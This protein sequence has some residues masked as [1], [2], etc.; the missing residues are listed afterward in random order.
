[1]DALN[2]ETPIGEGLWSP[3]S[4][5]PIT[6]HSTNRYAKRALADPFIME[7]PPGLFMRS[8][9]PE[10]GYLPPLWSAHIHPEGQLYFVHEGSLRVVMHRPETLEIA[11]C[12]IRYIEGLISDAE[13]TVS[14]DIELFLQLEGP[15]CAY[16]FVDHATCTQFWLESSDTERLDLPTVTS[17]SQ[18]RIVLEQLYWVHVEHFPMH[19][20]PLPISKLEEIISIFQHGLCDQMTSRGSTFNYT[21]K[22]CTVFVNILLGCRGNMNNGHT[23]WIIARLWSIVGTN[24]PLDFFTNNFFP[25][26]NRYLTFYG[27]ENSRLSREQSVLWDP[28]PKYPWIS[29]LLA[30]CTFKTSDLHLARLDDVFVDHM[31]Y[32]D[33]WEQ[34]VGDCLREWRVTMSGALAGIALHLPIFVLESPLPTMSIASTALL[35]SSLGSSVFLNHVYE[36]ME[37]LTA[38]DAMNYLDDIE[39]PVFKF[40]FTA[41]AFSLPK[42]LLLWGYLIL[43]ANGL[44]VV[45]KYLGVEAAFGLAGLFLLV[46]FTLYGTTSATSWSNV[47][48]ISW[49]GRTEAAIPIV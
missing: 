38:T 35:I 45:I 13:I 7:I 3:G 17:T 30:Y 14:G 9:E 19:L 25:D 41:L 6:S 23:T 31:V 37:H 11:W 8:K 47:M 42:A 15:D 22:D 43:L 46:A 48:N 36:P 39:S 28:E 40:Q 24:E 5:R 29:S 49:W 4:L 1:M 34:L 27:E 2:F 10:P 32:A 12:W 33:R 26:H 16:Y 21:A 20:Q 18:L 44:L